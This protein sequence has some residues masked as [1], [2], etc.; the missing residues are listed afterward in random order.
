ME[1]RLNLCAAWR[2]QRREL[3]GDCEAFLLGRLAER[4]ED[5]G[6]GVPAWAWTNLLAHGAA[7]DLVAECATE[8]HGGRPWNR[9]WRRARSY[10]AAEVLAMTGANET[11]A[12]LQEQ[13]LRP[14]ELDLAGS[15]RTRLWQP[16]QWVVHVA[17]AL[18]SHRVA[19]QGRQFHR[20]RRDR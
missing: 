13:V 17:T 1:R 3:V 11:L 12:Q 19:V 14:L 2:R 6:G 5:E 7:T 20:A 9:D 10:L 16:N 8:R 15:P 4:L 18:A